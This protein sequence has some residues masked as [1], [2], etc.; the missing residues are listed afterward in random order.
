MRVRVVR[1]LADCVD[2]VDLSRC[3]EGDLIDLTEHDARLIVAE[4]W[5]VPARR[6]SDSTA[7]A[8]DRRGSDVYQRLLDKHEQIEQERRRR[9]RRVDSPTTQPA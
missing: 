8:F 4:Q 3:G 2:G 6:V 7:E 5:A 9:E 1:K